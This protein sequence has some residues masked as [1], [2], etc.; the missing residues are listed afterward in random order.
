MM[1]LFLGFLISWSCTETKNEDLELVEVTTNSQTDVPFP[2]NETIHYLALGDSYTIGEGVASNNSWPKLLEQSLENNMKIEI[3]TQIIAKTGMTTR[4][5]INAI[6]FN[7]TLESYDLVSL[8]IG[9][10][11]QFRGMNIDDFENEFIALI[12]QSIAFANYKLNRVFVLSIPDWS[13]T[14]Y[15]QRLDHQKN[16]RELEQFNRVIK[17][18]CNAKNIDLFSITEISRMVKTQS[19]LLVKD[20]LHPSKK[21]YQLW[22]DKIL[23]Q[24]MGKL[25]D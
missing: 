18:V 9:V 10:N 23:S 11:N 3:E 16:K 1:L 8:L 15:G 24:I 22:V 19:D 14:P 21:M 13:A 7:D 17:N 6:A 12:D 25:N 4:D 5:L 2:N 20:N